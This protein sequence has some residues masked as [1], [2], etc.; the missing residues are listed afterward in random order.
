MACGS[1]KSLTAYWI[2]NRINAKNIIVAVPSLALIKQT[3]EVWTRESIANNIEINWL[4]VCSDDTV[5]ELENDVIISTTK[6]LG[7]DVSTDINYITNW[8]NNK[9][10]IVLS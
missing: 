8:L 6:D 5:S 1:G 10:E 7:I 4:A 3:L 9:N 2:A